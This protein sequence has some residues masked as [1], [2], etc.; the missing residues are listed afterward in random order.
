M[1]E[2]LH[3]VS[4]VGQQWVAIMTGS[5]VALVCLVVDYFTKYKIP[6]RVV[7]LAFGA[8]LLVACFLAWRVECNRGMASQK[9]ASLQAQLRAAAEEG[10]PDFL[11]TLEEAASGTFDDGKGNS[12]PCV[13]VI[14]S[15]ANRGAPSVVVSFRFTVKTPDGA[16]FEGEAAQFPDNFPIK[17][18]GGLVETTRNADDLLDKAQEKPIPHGGLVRGRVLYL[19]RGIPVGTIGSAGTVYELE[20]ADIWG[21][22]YA[23]SQANDGRS[24]V[25]RFYPQMRRNLRGP[26]DQQ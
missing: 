19:V 3:F 2:V 10:R 23:V 21:R 17:L 12:T 15:I 11:L 9:A 18:P 1:R 16:S 6:S 24:D 13:Q 4:A 22:K 5:L 7:L 25:P 26:S 14:A 8:G 20:V